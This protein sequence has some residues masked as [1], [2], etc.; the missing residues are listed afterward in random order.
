MAVFGEYLYI[1]NL[2]Q[3]R[4]RFWLCGRPENPSINDDDKLMFKWW[5]FVHQCTI[6]KKRYPNRINI[7]E[8]ILIL[9]TRTSY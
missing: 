9:K 7:Q 4:K 8:S 1:Y 2:F 3:F 5:R 6:E